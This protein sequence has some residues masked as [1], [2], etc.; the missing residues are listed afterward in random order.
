[1]SANDGQHVDFQ[2]EPHRND[3]LDVT[4]GFAVAFGGFFAIGTLFTLIQ[5]F[6]R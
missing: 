5:I 6:M 1:M 2:P 3:L 4:I